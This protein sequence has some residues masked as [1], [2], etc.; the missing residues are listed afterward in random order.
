MCN[1]SP[2]TTVTTQEGRTFLCVSLHMQPLVVFP[3]C[4][5]INETPG[6]QIHRKVTVTSKSVKNNVMITFLAV[7]MRV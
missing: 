3:M 4:S 1:V 6:L 2:S 7:D 5:F